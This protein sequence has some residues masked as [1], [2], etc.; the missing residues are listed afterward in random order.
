MKASEIITSAA[1]KSEENKETEEE[2]KEPENEPEK[3]P[4]EETENGKSGS[5]SETAPAAL[6]KQAGKVNVPALVL[7]IACA[8][9]LIIIAL[10]LFF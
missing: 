1:T 10:L 5:V 8:V 9:E 4:E 3:E 2:K 7:G 6:E